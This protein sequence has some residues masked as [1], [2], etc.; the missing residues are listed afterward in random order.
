MKIEQMK[1][2]DNEVEF[3]LEK[4]SPAYSNSLRRVALGEVPVMAI[5]EVNFKNNSSALY[6]EVIAHRLGLIPLVT[7]LKSYDL[8][9]SQTDIDERKAKSTL[10]LKL[11]V[12]GPKMVY[13]SDMKSADP[14]VVPVYPKIPIVKLLKDQELEFEAVAI[15][16]IGKE[17]AKWSAGHI[18][19]RFNPKLKINNKSKDFDKFKSLYPQGAFNKKGELDAEMILNNDLVDACEGVNKEILDITYEND[20]YLFHVESW[21]QLK[22]KEILLKSMD[23]LNQKL[24]EFGKLIKKVK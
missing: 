23:I 20:N 14:K 2:G 16:G 9:E 12:K 13:A 24:D 6:D 4:S 15:L 17:H 5:E 22:P 7:D 1:K 10:V 11:K 8:P 18:Y 19:Y 3:V 21:G